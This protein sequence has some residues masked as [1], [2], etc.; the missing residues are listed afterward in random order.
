MKRNSLA[1]L[2]LGTLLGL[3]WADENYR[4]ATGDTLGGISAKVGVSYLD[5]MAA[6]KMQNASVYPGQIL[7]IPTQRI[8]APPISAPAPSA[9]APRVAVSPAPPISPSPSVQASPVKGS[10]QRIPPPPVPGY[11]G[12]SP[13]KDNTPIGPAAGT[14]PPATAHYPGMQPT[15]PAASKPSSGAKPRSV[16]VPAAGGVTPSKNFRGSVYVVKPGDTVRS[17]CKKFGVAFWDLRKE[18]DI[19]FSTIRPGQILKIPSR[20]ASVGIAF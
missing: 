14:N 13:Y 15:R 19:L 7:I 16:E 17:I 1:V 4:V 10:S 11:S 2:M 8:P 9:P 18:N 6:N 5:I 20:P 12:T 3:S